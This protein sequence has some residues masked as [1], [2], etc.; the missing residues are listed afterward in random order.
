MNERGRVEP[1]WVISPGSVGV[2]CRIPL[3]GPPKGRRCRRCKE[4]LPF[5]AFRPNLKLKSGWSSW[6]R[7]CSAE[8]TRQWRMRHR[9]ELNERR[10]IPPTKLKCA[11][12]GE[13]FEGRRDR[14]VCSRRCKDRRYA[15]LHPEELRAK[16]AR[17]YQRR[18]A[19]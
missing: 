6:C 15:R 7:A 1:E 9:D 14:V 12:C 16:Q 4:F 18:K 3:Y 13:G 2:F 5:S 10:R 19:A 17:K 11:E 8:A